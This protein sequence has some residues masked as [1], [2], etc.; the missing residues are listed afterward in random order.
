MKV[1]NG[2]ANGITLTVTLTMFLSL[3]LSLFAGRFGGDERSKAL[4]PTPAKCMPEL[5]SVSLKVDD[6]P[7]SI[8]FP[9]CTRIKRCG[10]CCSSSL[11][12]C[13]P[14]VIETHNFEVIDRRRI[15]EQRERE[16]TSVSFVTSG[17]TRQGKSHQTSFFLSVV[18]VKGDRGVGEGSE[19]QK[20]PD[21]T[22]G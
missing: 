16:I 3:S 15:E 17:R 20:P 5:Q 19:L 2:I 14:T 21:R 12:S 22:T 9:S 10:G 11:L 18:L 8:I 13:Q 6:D 1:A 7:S 4:I